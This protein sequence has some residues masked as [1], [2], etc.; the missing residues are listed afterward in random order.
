MDTEK[1]R[2]FCRRHGISRLELFGS[3]LRKDFSQDSDVDFLAT[4]RADAH[5]TLLDWARMQEELAE[6]VGRPVDLLSRRA[7]ERSQNLYRRNSILRDT[8]PIYAEG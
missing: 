1:V 6:I 3:A 5:P 2:R 4:L 8:K 7:I